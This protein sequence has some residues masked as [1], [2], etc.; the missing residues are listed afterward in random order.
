VSNGRNQDEADLSDEALLSGMSVGDEWAGLVFVRRHQG[1]IFGLAQRILGEAS[2]A[3]DVAQEAFMRIFRHA[4]VYDARRGAVTT[5]AL[6]ITRNLAID[7]LRSRRATPTDP[8]EPLFL[9]LTGSTVSPEDVAVAQDDLARVRVALDDLPADQRRAL[10]LAAMYGRSAS[11]IARAEVIPL[12][13]AKS[14][15]RL[16]LAKLREVL[17][18][19]EIQ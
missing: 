4:A 16:G 15:V 3:E 14:R 11:E 9:D 17:A 1:R 12:G 8:D 7:T 13:T 5:W 6:T 10:L 2:L 18:I 19:E